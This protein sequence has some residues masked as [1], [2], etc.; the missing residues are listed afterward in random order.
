MEPV[1]QTPVLILGAT[2]RVYNAWNPG[3]RRRAADATRFGPQPAYTTRG[4]LG[5]KGEPLTRPGLG[6][7]PRIQRV[8]PWV[9]AIEGSSGRVEAHFDVGVAQTQ[10]EVGEDRAG[11][12]LGLIEDAGFDGVL[13]QH[14]V[15]DAA[16]V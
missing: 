7:S 13:H 9:F 14:L 4:T 2:A 1:A 6:H 8:E 3:L 5:C 11:V 12:V 15:S 16:H 10:E